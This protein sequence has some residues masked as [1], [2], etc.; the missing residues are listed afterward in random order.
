MAEKKRKRLLAQQE[1]PYTPISFDDKESSQGSI[2]ADDRLSP[3][4]SQSTI[5]SSISNI[6]S[7]VKTLS[8]PPS[9]SNTEKTETKSRWKKRKTSIPEV[10]A[11]EKIITETQKNKFEITKDS[12]LSSESDMFVV[13]KSEKVDES[14]F[15]EEF[16]SLTSVSPV[17]TE[18]SNTFNESK[19]GRE[20]KKSISESFMDFEDDLLNMDDDDDID[21]ELDGGG[22]DTDELMR[23]IDE[24]LS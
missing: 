17:K 5:S 20:E 7:P 12:K 19:K 22:K 9:A 11:P 21:L 13:D 15:D 1:K 23:E 16:T 4:P 24:M 3:T 14:G 6:S 18:P 2:S 10:S 8:Q